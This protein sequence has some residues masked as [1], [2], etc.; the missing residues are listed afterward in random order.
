[1]NVNNFVYKILAVFALSFLML[2]GY[3]KFIDY[4]AKAVDALFV[5][6]TISDESTVNRS[7]KINISKTDAYTVLSQINLQRLKENTDKN[8]LRFDAEL[9]RKSNCLSWKY[10]DPA[11]DKHKEINKNTII[12]Y[13]PQT[14]NE[15]VTTLFANPEYTKR[16]LDENITEIGISHTSTRELAIKDGEVIE[17]DIPNPIINCWVICVK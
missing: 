2:F 3:T 1:M 16:L 14:P 10:D 15:V 8:M 6:T 9:L 12:L 4:E 11:L 13:G 17:A 7:S 5:P